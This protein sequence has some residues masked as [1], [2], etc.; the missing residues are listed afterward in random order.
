MNTRN[1]VIHDKHGWTWIRFYSVN[2]ANAF[3]RFI[4][5]KPEILRNVVTRTQ[6]K[7][8]CS[9]NTAYADRVI[10]EFEHWLQ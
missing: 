4:R 5:T 6:Q 2:T 3:E 8:K 9:F 1:T 10:H 7:F